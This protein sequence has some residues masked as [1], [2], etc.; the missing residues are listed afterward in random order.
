M[1]TM[2]QWVLASRPT[3]SVEADNFRLQTVPVPNISEG[4]VLLKTQ[5]L[6]VAPV[7]LRYMKNEASFE[8]KMNIGD[9]MIGRGVGRVVASKNKDYTVGDVV[10]CK[11]GWREYA[12]ID[13]DPYYLA[14]KM[15]NTDLPLSH[16]ISSL[17]MSGFTALIGIRDICN[18]KPGDKVLVSGAAGG[19]GSQVAFIAKALGCEVVVGLAGGPDKSALLTNRLAYDAAIDYKNDN[20]DEK[21]DLLFPDGID[22]FFDNVGGVLLD[23]VMGRIRRRARIAIC[24][25]IS[26][27]LLKPSEYHRPKNFHN[28]ALQD[29]KTEGFFIYD[30]VDKYPEYEDTIAQ[31]IRQNRYFPLEDI[32]VG[33]EQ[34]PN[35]LLSLYSGQNKGIKMVKVDAGQSDIGNGRRL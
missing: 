10:Q 4:Q 25:R 11:L 12:V 24:G 31:W 17:A 29:A 18:L 16:G 9:V 1:D 30:Y 15:R 28:I 13:N 8:R 14:Y 32:S 34:M 20:I 2:K 5:Y 3:I 7:M 35:A 23:N 33:I 22:V 26:E 27:Y 21:L 6:G 19:V